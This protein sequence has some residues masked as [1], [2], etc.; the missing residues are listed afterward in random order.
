MTLRRLALCQLFLAASMCAAETS[1]AGVWVT[2]PLLGLAA[3][4]S[5]NPGLLIVDHSA[6]THGALLLDLPT[7][8]QS[9]ASS[10]SL[11]PSFRV[12]DSSGYS[13]IASDYE[14]F[15]ATGK[16]A[17]DLDT[18]S[19][20]GQL[21]RDSSLYY[22]YLFNGSEGVRR[23]ST[24][25]DATWM[26]SL[27]E[28]LNFLLDVNSSRVIYGHPSSLS[29]A[30]LTDYDYTS[31]APTLVWNESERTKLKLDGTF[32]LYEQAG[33]YTKSANLNL[34]A[35]LTHQLTELWTVDAN[36]GYS[37]ERNRI[38]EYLSP[39]IHDGR[40]YGPYL[41]GV[42]ESSNTGSVYQVDVS[43][44]G[45]SWTMTGSV[46]RSLVP[47]GFAFLARQTAYQFSV[48]YPY[49][50]RLTLDG[51]VQWVKSSEPEVLGP[52]VNQSYLGATASAKWLITEKWSV[53]LTTMRVTA[54]YTSIE[55]VG[56]TGVSL[57]F[58]RHFN[59]IVWQ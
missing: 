50:E 55:E 56:T 18:L 3:E 8:Y 12:S 14:H 37:K 13:S 16:Y 39:V 52:T 32:G 43:R 48:D 59:E 47:T 35:G 45:I 24:L 1:R 44:T 15:T 22:D 17:S 7:S 5:T 40:S 2:D 28:R 31:A 4:F 30:I 23:D 21:A 25:A 38:E 27:S 9:E 10:L 36:A 34:E 26:R 6:E 19:L 58:T 41:V 20:M 49:N 46:S 53:T 42:F 54:K 33:G 57:Q 11:E 29:S 51:S